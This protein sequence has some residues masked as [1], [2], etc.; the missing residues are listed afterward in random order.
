MKKILIITLI[1]SLVFC[2]ASCSGNTSESEVNKNPATENIE[3][4]KDE[5]GEKNDLNSIVNN[6][7]TVK[8]VEEAPVTDESFF[9]VDPWYSGDGVC[10]TEY[11]GSDAIVVIPETIGGKTVVEIADGAFVNAET[12]KG[13]RFADSIKVLGESAFVNSE[14]IEVIVTGTGLKTI[15]EF[16]ISCCPNLKQV[17]LNDGLE[18]IEA[19]GIALNDGLKELYIPASVTEVGYVPAE[20]STIICEAGSSAEQFAIDNGFDYKLK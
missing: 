5:S 14:S 3:N 11:T 9:T 16:A 6:E 19:G 13:V 7:I 17:R 18:I 2:F 12:I 10:I 20:G 15:E 8:D 4:V 1:L